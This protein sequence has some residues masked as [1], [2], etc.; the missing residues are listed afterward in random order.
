MTKSHK[1]S[2]ILNVFIFLLLFQ[3]YYTLCK[4]QVLSE[5]STPSLP[6]TATSSPQIITNY[7]P[8]EIIFT[9]AVWYG[10]AFHGKKMANGKKFDMYNPTL[11][12]HRSLP[13]G[14]KIKVVNMK[15]G[16]TIDAIVSDRG[17]YA[18]NKKTKEYVAGIDLSY[19][20]AKILEIDK[21]GIADVKI[22]VY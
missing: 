20:A 2:L 21:I 3:L 12:A 18:K 16:I 5:T 6:I 9:R 4:A 15:N 22:K 17:P 19:A 7:F 11:V 10:K 13:L 1:I 8:Q 14:T